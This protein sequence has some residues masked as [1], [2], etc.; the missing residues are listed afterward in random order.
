MFGG[1]QE[2]ELRPGTHN[3]PG[4]VG[5]AKAVEIA[6]ENR[7]RETE[8]IRALRD[9]FEELL[10]EQFPTVRRNG[11]LR[12]RLAGNSSLTFPGVDAEALVANLPDIAVSTGSACSSGAIDPSHV[13]T[14]I[15]LSRE[16]AHETIRVGLGRFTMENEVLT[17]AARIAD[18]AK[19]VLLASRPEVTSE[20]A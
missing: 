5:L 9:R 16:A 4:I 18:A 11:C 13:L 19:S 12:R 8:R 20:V 3:V 7:E 10:A 14:A 6:T 15:G 17:A 2:G 1:G